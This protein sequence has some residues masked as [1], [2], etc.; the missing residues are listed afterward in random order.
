MI[1]LNHTSCE[2]FKK[3]AIW[4][5]LAVHTARI[6]EVHVS[7]RGHFGRTRLTAK[8]L[9]R[10]YLGHVV[11]AKEI[12]L[13]LYAQLE[14]LKNVTLLR[15]AKVVALTED[16]VTVQIA[17]EQRIIQATIFAA[18]DGTFSTVR[19]LLNIPTDIIDYQQKALVTIT[20]LT[21]S[22]QHIA[23]ERF[24]LHGAI[25]MLP[26]V[27]TRVATIW[28]G[29]QKTID[30]LVNLSE[31]HFLQLL[32]KQFGYRLGRL[33]KIEERFTYPLKYVKAK[34]TIQGRFILLG[35]AAHTIH[36]IAAQGLNLALYEVALLAKHL[37]QKLSLE[38]LPNFFTQEK[39]SANLSH[40]L[41][42]I[43]S[44]DFFGANTAR[45]WGM[46]GLDLCGTVKRWFGE[47]II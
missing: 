27:G 45:Q 16:T 41:T 10:P 30:E 5:A 42:Q 47:K 24:I 35:N 34:E 7:N 23:Y 20:E 17:K 12:N 28:S 11:P 40:Q 33:Q 13:A 15:G 21:R 8:E 14:K 29:E 39:T 18:A 1:A 26:L 43:F 31:E 32:Q 25:A 9:E 46:I 4:P 38:N 44:W 22:H 3:L 36:P 2:F 19:E 37:S 6:D